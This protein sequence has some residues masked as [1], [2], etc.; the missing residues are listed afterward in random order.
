MVSLQF[1]AAPARTYITKGH[2]DE[3]LVGPVWCRRSNIGG[4]RYRRLGLVEHHI[5]LMKERSTDQT[6]VKAIFARIRSAAGL[7]RW[8]TELPIGYQGINIIS[9]PPIEGWIVDAYVPKF[10]AGLAGPVRGSPIMCSLR[11]RAVP[12]PMCISRSGRCA[13]QGMTMVQL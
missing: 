11:I 4:V 5:I 6:K 7:Q 2:L 1:R 3:S 9:R 13:V 10:H 12:L 8:D